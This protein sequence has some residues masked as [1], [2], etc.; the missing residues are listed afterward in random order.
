MPDFNLVQVLIQ[1]GAV[2]IALV[3]LWVIYK[4]VSNHDEHLQKVVERNSDAWIDN[5][6]ALTKLVSTLELSHKK[7]E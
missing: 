3:A 5:T 6:K 7:K 1:G 4:L 2:G